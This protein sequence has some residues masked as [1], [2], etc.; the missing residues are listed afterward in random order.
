[1][2]W[3]SSGQA[4]AQIQLTNATGRLIGARLVRGGAQSSLLFLP[5]GYRGPV[6]VQLVAI[7]RRGDRVTEST[8]LGGF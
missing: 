3:T 8:Q 4:L 5:R 7:G 6:Y 2:N 1:V